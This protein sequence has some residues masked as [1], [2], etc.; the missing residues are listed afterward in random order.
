M[1]IIV[2]LYPLIDTLVLSLE[3][4]MKMHMALL[5]I[6]LFLLVL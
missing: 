3:I 2:I 6:V 4:V 1:T 5:F